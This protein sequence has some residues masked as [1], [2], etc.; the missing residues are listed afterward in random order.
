MVN[1]RSRLLV[2]LL[3]L[4]Q[5]G[6]PLLP[7]QTTLS[8][9]RGVVVGRN[10]DALPGVTVTLE[11]ASSSQT[12]LGAVT[13]ARGEFRISPVPPGKGYK[14]LADLSGY[15]R[16]EFRDVEIP[17]GRTV[18]QNI[19]LRPRLF[20]RFRVPVRP[21]VVRVDHPGVTARIGI[22]S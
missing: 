7:A 19:T 22:R 11:N 6:I 15:Q 1:G 2:P 10:G 14:L 12:R 13:N 21:E 8:T 3:L 16:I 20:K 18:V 4:V 9:L 5:S 17:A